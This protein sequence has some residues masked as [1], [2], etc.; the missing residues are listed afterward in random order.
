VVALAWLGRGFIQKRVNLHSV[1]TDP[2][3]LYLLLW[4]LAPM[5]FFTVSGNILATYVLP[6]LP[7]FALLVGDVWRP[8]DDDTRALRS[9]VRVLLVVGLALPVLFVAGILLV[10]DKFE[11][12]LSHKALVQ[13]WTGKRA[14]NGERLVYVGRPPPSAEF[15]SRG[16]AMTVPDAAT[17]APLLDDPAAD[18]IAIRAGDLARLPDATRSLLVPLGEFGDFRLLHESPR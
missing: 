15:Y 8:R 7:A 4:T 3:R 17:L 12:E 13:T 18:F 5:V 6:G 1:V 9:P 16:K 2:W 11:R 14:N 10:H